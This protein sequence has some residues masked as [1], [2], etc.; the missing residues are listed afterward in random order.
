MLPIEIARD[1]ELGTAIEAINR[2]RAGRLEGVKDP[3]SKVVV[4]WNDEPGSTWL[5]VR[6]TNRFLRKVLGVPT[7]NAQRVVFGMDYLRIDLAR[8]IPESSDDYQFI[9]GWIPDRTGEIMMRP[10]VYVNYVNGD[11]ELPSITT[12]D[13]LA[14]NYKGQR[15]WLTIGRATP[16]F[17]GNLATWLGAEVREENI[18]IEDEPKH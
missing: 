12:A 2:K 9:A 10:I 17:L 15:T 6:D 4:L 8:S 18:R 5:P 16:A 13:Y 1:L 14:E 11:L 7:I 3:D